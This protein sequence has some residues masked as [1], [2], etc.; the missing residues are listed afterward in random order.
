MTPIKVCS[1]CIFVT[2]GWSSTH[3]V[4]TMSFHDFVFDNSGRACAAD[5]ATSN[6]VILVRS[7][8]FRATLQD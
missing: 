6:A 1:I 3:Q 8:C 4:P 2:L 5:V 7:N